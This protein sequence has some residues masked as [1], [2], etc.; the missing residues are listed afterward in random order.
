M[1]AQLDTAVAPLAGFPAPQEQLPGPLPN[2]KHENVVHEQPA[3]A[4][5]FQVLVAQQSP[6]A[7]TVAAL[8]SCAAAPT[9]WVALQSQ[10]PVEESVHTMVSGGELQATP[11][12]AARMNARKRAICR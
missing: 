5:V 4:P 12:E 1:G 8:Q 11:S 2:E 9:A 10:R 7:P 6:G 3:S